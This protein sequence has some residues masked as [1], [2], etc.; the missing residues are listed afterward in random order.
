MRVIFLMLSR[1]RLYGRAYS[2]SWRRTKLSAPR[3]RNFDFNVGWGITR[4]HQVVADVDASNYDTTFM[5]AVLKSSAVKAQMGISGVVV[6]HFT[7]NLH[8]ALDYFRS[9]TSWWAGEKEAV[10]AFSAGMTLT[11]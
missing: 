6:Y 7:P 4:V 5:P 11:W 8:G 2:C 3:N 10:N 9:D 1:R